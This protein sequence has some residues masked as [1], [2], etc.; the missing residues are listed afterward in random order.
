MFSLS[1]IGFVEVSNVLSYFLDEYNSSSSGL[2]S[3]MEF[4]SDCVVLVAASI[5]SFFIS[6]SIPVDL[7]SV[8]IVGLDCSLDSRIAFSF[9]CVFVVVFEFCVSDC[10]MVD[11]DGVVGEL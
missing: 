4:G 6:R 9:V 7:V 2:D 3:T 11:V 1:L 10:F 8:K 5:F